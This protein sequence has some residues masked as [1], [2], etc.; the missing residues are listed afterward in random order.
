MANN[1]PMNINPY[2]C[3]VEPVVL[4]VAVVVLIQ[5]TLFITAFVKTAKF[6]ITSIGSVQKSADCVFFH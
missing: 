4:S 6:V 5:G 2:T 3:I 1:E